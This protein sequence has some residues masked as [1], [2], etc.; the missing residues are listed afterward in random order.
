MGLRNRRGNGEDADL[1]TQEVGTSTTPE[2]D[3][4][5]HNYIGNTYIVHSYNQ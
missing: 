5:R 1:D 2:L 4:T 3:T